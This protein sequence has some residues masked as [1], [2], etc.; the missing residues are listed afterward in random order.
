MFLLSCGGDISGPDFQFEL[1]DSDGVF[2]V[3]VVAVDHFE[4]QL[5]NG[6]PP[7]NVEKLKRGKTIHVSVSVSIIY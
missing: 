1:G 2:G 5:L 4:F 7:D 3:I 6:R